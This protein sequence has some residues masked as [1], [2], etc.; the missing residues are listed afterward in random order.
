MIRK[1]PLL[2]TPVIF[3]I[4]LLFLLCTAGQVNPGSDTDPL[5]SGKGAFRILVRV[6]PVVLG[7]RHTD[8]WPARYEVNFKNLLHK[9]GISGEVDLSS[10]Q[11]QKY[12]PQTGEGEP[13]KH[14]DNALTEYD[15]PCRFDDDVLPEDYP[16]R[17]GHPSFQADGRLPII[18]TKRKGRLFDREMDNTAG[19]IVWV[20][21]QQGNE[22]SYY[23][24]YFDV[25]TSKRGPGL[26]PSPWIGDVDVLRKS[27]GVSIAVKSHFKIA[28]GDLNGDGLFDLVA[29]TEKGDLMWYPNRGTPGQPEFTGCRMLFDEQGPIDVGFYSVPF[30]YD[31]DGDGLSD[32][33]VGTSKNV[34]LWWKNIGT[35]SEHKLQY[36]GFIQ[37]DGGR[38]ELPQS[39]VPED[40]RGIFSRDYYNQPWVG[41]WDGDG[42]PDIL[43]GGY[44]TGLIFHYRCTD[45]D[46]NGVPILA[47]AGMLEADGKPIDATWAAS[48]T[49]Y[50]FNGDG[51]L[52]L[53]TGSWWWSGIPY[54]PEPGQADCLMYYEN[55]GTRAQPRLSR[56]DIPG[57]LT[58]P[59]FARTTVVDWNN[60]G[61]PDLLVCAGSEISVIINKGTRENP[62]WSDRDAL[63]MEIPWGIFRAGW[64]V[65]DKVDME[66]GGV[67]TKVS[68]SGDRLISV[69]E[70]TYSPSAME[71]IGRANVGGKRISHPGPG[72][73]DPYYF[74]A[75]RDWDKDGRPDLLW[76][77]HQGNIYLH[78]H[79]GSADPFAFADG[80]KLQLT[81]GDDLK[82]GPPVAESPAQVTDF[83]ILQG[84]R[85][86]FVAEDF[87]GDGIDDLA[88]TDTYGDVW[89]F[90]NSES[91]GT[92]TLAPGIKVAKYKRRSNQGF[93]AV[94]WDGDGRMDILSSGTTTEPGLLLL[95]K[96]EPG[97]LAFSEPFRPSELKNLPYVF[98]GPGF[99]SVDW[100]GDG[101]ADLLIRS[102]YYT[103]WAERSFLARGYGAVN[104]TGMFQ[105]R[106]KGNGK[107]N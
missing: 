31:W 64:L 17:I 79:I 35:A 87:N 28:A 29:G 1:S 71:E 54:P 22:P 98:W 20:H 68:I 92:N 106:S 26:S 60:D 80:V 83:T 58:G 78:R 66:I 36:M 88:V 33:L 39:P 18:I 104:S 72:Y 24:I 45:R 77:T 32:I 43:T 73:G 76:G 46:V 16:S 4:G 89:I 37:A 67:M 62:E 75:L 97:K 51:K 103:F 81:T 10:L 96:S 56:R 19:Q 86:A 101:D 59:A 84:S 107:N 57:G 12:H 38:L 5:W 102:E 9:H 85:I 105:Q 30:V 69:S 15:R 44:T 6:E 3:I 61:L 21:T 49:A 55:T 25:L 53:L 41:D 48:P 40:T 42:L 99:H 94:D 14:F 95:N 91:G 74:S 63:R 11:V 52:E 7:D 8:E 2:K 70:S 23:A 90:C 82:V 47:Y 100:N 13:F 34:I 50:D 27:E 93:R 65:Y